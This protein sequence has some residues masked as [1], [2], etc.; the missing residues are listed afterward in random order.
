ML[1]D[2]AGAEPRPGTPDDAVGGVVPALVV[3]P[4]DE[5]AAARVMA[6]AAR[7]GL[8]AVFRGGGT[9]LDWGGPPR[10]ADLLV[11]TA[12]LTGIEHTADDLVVTVGAGTP[13]AEL[14]DVL[15]AAGQRLSADPVRAGGT[16]GGMVATGVCGPR[17]LLFGALR[18]LVIGMTVVRADGVVTRT[19]GRVVKNVAGY[20]LAKLHTGG[21]GTL[22]LI[23]SVTFRLHPA[24]PA[25]R[26]VTAAVSSRAH[27]ERMAAALRARPVAPSAVALDWPSEGGARLHVV[28]EGMAEGMGA[29]VDGVRAALGGDTVVSERLPEGWGLVPARGTLGFVACPPADSVAAAAWIGELVRA[30]DADVLVR[31]SVPSGALYAAFPPGTGTAVIAGVA[32]AVRSRPGW[33][34]T[35]TRAEPHVREAGVD[36]W[37]EVP[38]IALMRS[39]K[40]ALDPEHRLAPGRFVGGI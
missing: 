25:L 17:R 29:R 38:G 37:G 22:G 32:E 1:D 13:V 11:D 3:R 26:V 36:P 21:L 28:L 9:A 8:S 23:T 4:P 2:L 16:V 10:S 30:A 20:D 24:P 39:V 15:A 34:L 31:G 6:V 18:D 35:L 5:A 14:T 33:S 27:G 12:A 19:G 7:H 40:D